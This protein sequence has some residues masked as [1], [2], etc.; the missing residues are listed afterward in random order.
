MKWQRSAF[1]FLVFLFSFQRS[2]LAQ[3]PL[4]QRV[5]SLGSM[6]TEEIYLLGSDDKLIADTIYCTRPSAAQFKEKIGNVQ[7]VNLEKIVALRPD[8][9]L[10]TELTDPRAVQKLRGMGLHVEVVATA[11][12]FEQICTIFL[13]LGKMLGKEES[14]RRIVADARQKVDGLKYKLSGTKRKSVFVQVGTNPLF[15]AGSN[16]FADDFIQFGGGVNIVKHSD[17]SE[18]SREQVMNIDPDAIIIS[19]M[20]FDGAIEKKNW[21]KFTMLKAVSGGHV[22][23]IDQYLLCSPTPVS[24]VE[25]LKIMIHDLHP[26]ILL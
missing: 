22:F 24:F 10:A 25:T 13:K 3:E 20:G 4:P 14:A 19:S 2:D 26:E 6:V 23:I 11:R 21:Q 15:A 9:V 16:T 5:I 18:F 8:L 7:E 12:N 17:Y 1:Y